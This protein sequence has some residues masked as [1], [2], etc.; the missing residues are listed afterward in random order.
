M[1]N[2]SYT[3]KNE[4]VTIQPTSGNFFNLLT[5]TLLFA[6]NCCFISFRTAA[7]SAAGWSC[8]DGYML[9]H[10][11]GLSFISL[12]MIDLN[13]SLQKHYKFIP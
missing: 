6:I 3:Q 4:T 11:F 2:P 8:H 10:Y 7:S 13:F 5:H 1:E 9:F 12:T